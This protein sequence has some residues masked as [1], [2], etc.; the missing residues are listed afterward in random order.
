MHNGH[1]RK[2]AV[3]DGPSTERMAT[4]L[5]LPS[6]HRETGSSAANVRFAG[7]NAANDVASVLV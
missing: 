1:R 3:G 4:L 5:A 2:D 6:D 7:P